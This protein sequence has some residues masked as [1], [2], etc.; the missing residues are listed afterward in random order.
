MSKTKTLVRINLSKYK[1]EEIEKKLNETVEEILNNLLDRGG[2]DGW[3]SD[4]EESTQQEIKEE[5][6]N[7]MRKL[8][9]I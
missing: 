9:G 5:L 2:F 7:S 3:W 8:L 1:M 4:I 6:K